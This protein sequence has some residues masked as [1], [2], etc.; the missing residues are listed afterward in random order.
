[1]GTLLLIILHG[2][3]YNSANFHNFSLVKNVNAGQ[4]LNVAG[5]AYW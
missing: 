1:M 2:P 3:K 4:S 5:Q